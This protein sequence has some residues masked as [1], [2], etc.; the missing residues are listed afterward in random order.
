[1]EGLSSRVKRSLTGG[2][3]GSCPAHHHDGVTR[4]G[5]KNTSLVHSHQKQLKHLRRRSRTGRTSKL[6]AHARTTGTRGED[7][8]R[9]VL[10]ERTEIER[11]RRRLKQEL[12]T[13]VEREDYAQAAG[14]RDE[15]LDLDCRD[16]IYQ[17]ETQLEAAVADERYED[18]ASLRDQLEELCPAPK[19]ESDCV[20]NG[21]RVKVS[22]Y[23]VPSRSSPHLGQFFFTYK[24]QISNEGDK[25]IQVRN[26]HWI[27]TNAQGR[28]DEVKG[29]GVVGEQPILRPGEFFEY[30]SACP[31]QTSYGTMEGKYEMIVFS[32]DTFDLDEAERMEVKIG[33]FSLN[34][35]ESVPNYDCS[36]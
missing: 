22:S 9:T 15:L 31:L 8:V 32:S 17:L 18:A 27:I 30:T 14:L 19:N 21:I 36:I 10:E 5:R 16:P 34:A 6:V 28:T 13:A 11:Q 29:P 7:T 25:T 2:V 1:M 24:V 26:R 4:G 3:G 35:T 33:K 20:T 12:T 23:Y